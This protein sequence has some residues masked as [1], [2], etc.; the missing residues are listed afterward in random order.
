[1][2]DAKIPTAA[3][4]EQARQNPGGWVYE[5]GRGVDLAGR[6]PP[7]AIV[8]YWKVDANGEIVGDFVPNPGHDPDRYPPPH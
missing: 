1:M 2:G 3:A 4:R 7:A 8:G 6:I 5:I